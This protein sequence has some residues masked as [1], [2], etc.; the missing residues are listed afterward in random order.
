MRDGNAAGACCWP[1]G[2]AAGAGVFF[3]SPFLTHFWSTAIRCLI[4]NIPS[5]SAA[6]ATSL[7][8]ISALL[9]CRRA[10]APPP[11]RR[12]MVGGAAPSSSLQRRRRAPCSSSGASYAARTSGGGV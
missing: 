7:R 12:A 8:R 1:L 2:A 10:G 11:P 4:K 5:P 9:P 6:C 3:Q